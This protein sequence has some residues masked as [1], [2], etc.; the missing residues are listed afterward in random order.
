MAF[1]CV[2]LLREHKHTLLSKVHVSSSF[3]NIYNRLVK[4]R[5]S[6]A[7]HKGRELSEGRRRGETQ[8]IPETPEE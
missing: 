3:S 6:Y 4:D 7:L 8:L 2:S 1:S 5:M